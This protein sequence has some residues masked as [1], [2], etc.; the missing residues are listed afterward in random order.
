MDYI[1]ILFVLFYMLFLVIILILYSC[2]IYKI[3]CRKIFGNCLLLVNCFYFCSR[4]KVLKMFIVIVICFVFCWLLYYVL[5]FLMFYDENFYCGF[6]K[7][8]YFLVY[9][10]LY[11]ISVV[12]LCIYLMFNK[13]YWNGVNCLLF[14]VRRLNVLYFENIRI[15]VDF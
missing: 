15:D 13:D 6:F 11:V 14:C 4:R 9:F 10:L 5:F 2:V 7:D 12:N 8:F 1:I 3:W